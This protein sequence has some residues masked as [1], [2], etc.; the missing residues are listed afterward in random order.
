VVLVKRWIEQQSCI[1]LNKN[2]AAMTTSIDSLGGCGSE[3][4]DSE[5][6][7]C[8]QTSVSHIQE[9]CWVDLNTE[10]YKRSTWLFG[11]SI[12]FYKQWDNWKK[13]VLISTKIKVPIWLG[14]F[15]QM[16]K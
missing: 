2:D 6:S 11:M 15:E 10:V 8:L 5:S 16:L 12:L 14:L 13:S 4:L 3:S 7:D 9:M 1:K